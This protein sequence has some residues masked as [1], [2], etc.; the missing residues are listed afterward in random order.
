MFYP[1]LGGFVSQITNLLL[2]NKKTME[3]RISIED[4]LGVIPNKFELTV[5]AMNRAKELLLGATSEVSEGRFTKKQV[6][7]ALK[8]IES[9]MINMDILRGKIKEYLSN[10][11]LFSKDVK[12]AVDDV[13][14]TDDEFDNNDDELRDADTGSEDEDFDLS[15]ADDFDDEEK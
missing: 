12:T 6:N 9:K 13:V 3:E 7:K 14:A 10:N 5:L 4:C 1:P 15:L 11:E 2:I 8:E